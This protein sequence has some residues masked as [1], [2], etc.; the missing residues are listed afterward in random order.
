MLEFGFH[1]N[2]L[3]A[4]AA[5]T[6]PDSQVFFRKSWTTWAIWPTHRRCGNHAGWYVMTYMMAAEKM[7]ES[8]IENFVFCSFSHGIVL[9]RRFRIHKTP[10]LTFFLLQKPA[11]TQILPCLLRGRGSGRAIKSQDW[12][13]WQCFCRKCT[14]AIWQAFSGRAFDKAWFQG[15]SWGQNLMSLKVSK[16]LHRRVSDCCHFL[17]VTNNLSAFRRIWREKG[18]YILTTGLVHGSTMENAPWASQE[19]F[20]ADSSHSML[21]FL[22]DAS[23]ASRIGHKDRCLWFFHGRLLT[24]NVSKNWH[25]NHIPVL[26]NFGFPR[27]RGDGL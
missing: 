9:N 14:V 4:V 21:F 15:G 17:G 19:H 12:V 7:L 16:L 18:Y 1:S 23:S 20:M 8:V 2:A 10:D 3:A 27:L 5:T 6:L 22:F 13:Q 24:G 26:P 25:Y 11:S